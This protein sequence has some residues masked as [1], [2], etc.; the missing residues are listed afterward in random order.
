MIKPSELNL[1]SLPSV[2]IEN[3]SQLPS[4]PCIY[5]AIDALGV[6]Q[7]IGRSVNPKFRWVAHH[8]QSTLQKIGSIKI[9]Y[10]FIDLPEL[11]PSIEE[12]LIEW[13]QPQLNLISSGRGMARFAS[14]QIVYVPGLSQR[15]QELWI[16]GGKQGYNRFSVA[17]AARH[18]D[19]TECYWKKLLNG[20]T[21]D[22]VSVDLLRKIERFFAV[23]FGVKIND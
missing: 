7:Y 16:S 22:R 8:K 14:D 1:S 11:L 13:F 19:L 23:D 21:E 10:L 2:S 9:S 20:E 15:L 5:F 6:V 4:T 3:R 12:A 18:L 17:K